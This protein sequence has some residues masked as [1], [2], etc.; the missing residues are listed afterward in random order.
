VIGI[1]GALIGG[2]VAQVAGQR[3]VDEFTWWSLLVAFVGATV[4]LLVLGA[5]ERS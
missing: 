4:L 3:G 5:L 1:A 2:A